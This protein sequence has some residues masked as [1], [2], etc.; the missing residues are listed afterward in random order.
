MVDIETTRDDIQ[1]SP[2]DAERDAPFAHSWFIRPEG[3]DT[4]LRMGNAARD[5]ADSTLEGE[6]ATM[7]QFINLEEQGKQITRAIRVGA[8]T[9]GVSWIELCNNHGVRSP[10]VHIMIGDVAYRGQGIGT[11]VME[12]MIRYAFVTLKTHVVY[13]RHLVNNTVVTKLNHTLGFMADGA[14]Y[15]DGNGLLWQNVMIVNG[16]IGGSCFITDE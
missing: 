4:L 11:T 14:P 8:T 15:E 7:R 9:I 1:L 6:R 12:T 13:S 10:S 5:I 2:I 3:R 16:G